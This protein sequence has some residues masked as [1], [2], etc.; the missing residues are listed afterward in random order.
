[1]LRLLFA[2]PAGLLVAG[3]FFVFLANI[4]GLKQVPLPQAQPLAAIQ[5]FAQRH[6]RKPELVQRRPLVPPHLA[7]TTTEFHFSPPAT[8]VH[9]TQANIELSVS[10]IA[11]PLAKVSLSPLK[12]PALTASVTKAELSSPITY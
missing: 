10:A 3:S 8:S 1:M 2:F 4:S 5:L 11:L 9:Q 6:S 12:L 7:P